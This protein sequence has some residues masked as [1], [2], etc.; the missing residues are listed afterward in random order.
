[1]LRV[2]LLAA[3]ER[4]A[5]V[6]RD[7]VRAVERVEAA[8]ECGVTLAMGREPAVLKDTLVLP[9]GAPPNLSE[10][11]PLAVLVLYVAVVA[12][13]GVKRRLAVVTLL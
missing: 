11:C 5:V 6:N 4:V 1:L 8:A 13:L 9:T 3:P 2:A 10:R 12:A 7:W